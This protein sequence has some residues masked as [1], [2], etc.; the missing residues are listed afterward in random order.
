MLDAFTA[1]FRAFPDGHSHIE[2]LFEDGQWVIIE[3]S[4]IGTMTASLQ[5]IARRAAISICAAVNSSLSRT[6]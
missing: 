3:W 5:D 1:I 2:Q 4:F 6:A